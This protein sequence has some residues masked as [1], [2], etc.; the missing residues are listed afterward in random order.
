MQPF[1]V[2]GLPPP[3][4]CLGMPGLLVSV[5]AAIV[6]LPWATVFQGGVPAFGLLGLGV[7]AGISS[8]IYCTIRGRSR[9]TAS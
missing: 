1:D 9:P 6:A 3:D 8:V 4:E 5:I 7:L 2:L